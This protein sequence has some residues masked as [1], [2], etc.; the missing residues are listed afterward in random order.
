M[1]FT[2]ILLAGETE[3]KRGKLSKEEDKEEKGE[4]TNERHSKDDDG[5][6]KE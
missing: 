5:E 1:A 3:E 4:R 2:N 6:H